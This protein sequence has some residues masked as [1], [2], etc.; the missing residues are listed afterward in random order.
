MVPATQGAREMSAVGEDMVVPA[1]QETLGRA[2]K[3]ALKKRTVEGSLEE[4]TL[5]GALE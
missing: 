3:G 4:L 2:L 5:E 1:V